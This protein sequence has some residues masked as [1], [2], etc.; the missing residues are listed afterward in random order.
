MILS[1]T[2]YNRLHFVDNNMDKIILKTIYL[3]LNNFFFFI[4]NLKLE[5]N[6]LYLY[7]FYAKGHN[8]LH[9]LNITQE[10]CT[11]SRADLQSICGKP[12]ML[13]IIHLYVRTRFQAG[14]SDTN[15]IRK[16]LIKCDLVQFLH[17]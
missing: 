16:L 14:Q 4:I 2:R 13:W 17:I 11:S 9:F 1:I 15:K 6:T 10:C 12:Y 5:K 8:V 7:T 3:Y